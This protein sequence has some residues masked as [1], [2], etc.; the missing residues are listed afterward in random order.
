[1]KIG[2]IGGSDGLGK[3]LIY[4]F[5]DEFKVSISARDHDKGRKVAEEMNVDYVESNKKLAAMSNILIISVPIHHTPSVIRE[6]A[7]FMKKGSVMIDVTSVKEKPLKTME[8]CLPDNVE[9]IPTHPVFGPRTTELDN[10]VIVLTAT[11]KGKWY[12]KVYDYLD[13][14]NMRIIET[15]AHHHDYMM[16]IV[17][18]LT[19]FSFISTAS[20]MEKLK[21]DITETEDYESPIYNLMID[22]IARI[23]SQNPYLT[24]YIQTM[25]NNGTQ[26]RNAFSEAVTELRDVIEAKNDEKFVEIAINATK[27]MGD[28]QNALG[29][30]DKAINGLNHEFNILK[31]SIGHEIALEHIYSGKVHIG[32]LEKIDGKSAILD[33]G[34]KLRIANI[35]V[36][37]DEELYQWRLENTKQ[38]EESISCMFPDSVTP[39]IIVETIENIQ[40][41]TEVILTDIYK[42][43]QIAEGY[44]SLTFNVKALNKD[45]INNVKKVLTGFGGVLR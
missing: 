41:I 29:R 26:I 14:K 30:S 23:V 27:N 31:K 12:E 42:G 35:R 4:Y 40:D 28:I 19:H 5:R 25:N 8:E 17:Q 15:T 24:Y 10:Q 20:A 45:A 32:V 6:V 39:N 16:S 43:P 44:E 38:K 2:I 3:T 9:F 13:S 11:K 21:V 37:N 22:M 34:T 36:L 33:N 1:M 7:P 18:V